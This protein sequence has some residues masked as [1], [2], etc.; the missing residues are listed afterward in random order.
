MRHSVNQIGLWHIAEDAA[1]RLKPSRTNREEC[2]EAWIERDPRVLQI[3]PRGGLAFD[4]TSPEVTV[5]QCHVCGSRERHDEYVNE[6]FISNG[7]PVL[8]EHIPARVCDRC[9]EISFSR[10][11]TESVRRLVH[12]DVEP[13]R[14]AQVKVF[15]FA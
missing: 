4:M 12:G 7:E 1:E 10:Q 15:Q 9:R 11:T 3:V 14:A 5:S 13:S 6:V 2:L 8:V